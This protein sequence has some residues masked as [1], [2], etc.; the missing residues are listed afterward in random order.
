MRGATIVFATLLLCA[1]VGSGQEKSVPTGRPPQFWRASASEQNGKIVIQI[2]A[3]EERAGGGGPGGFEP[4]V[5]SL[6][7]TRVIE[8]CDLPKVTLGEQVQAL[9]VD[10]KVVEPKAVLKSLA[11]PR[12]VAVFVRTKQDAR[13]T[14]DPFYLMLLRENDIVL[15]VNE[16]GIYPDQP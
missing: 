16:T 3:P 15:V 6:P 4:G 9:R 11:K 5:R 14:P 8:W 7:P 12:G 1:R 10:G 13:A 2:A